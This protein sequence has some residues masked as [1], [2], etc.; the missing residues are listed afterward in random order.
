MG[1]LREGDLLVRLNDVNRTQFPEVCPACGADATSSTRI[2][3]ARSSKSPNALN[4]AYES[5][6]SVM[7]AR[8]SVGSIEIPVCDTHDLSYE[9]L[10]RARGV[11][12]MVGGISLVALFIMSFTI[13]GSLATGRSLS[14]LWYLGLGMTLLLLALS[15]KLTGPNALEKAISLVH[16]EPQAG[17][18]ILRIKNRSYAERIV[19][20]NPMQAELGIVKSPAENSSTSESPFS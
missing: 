9:E 12:T 5:A 13:L 2:A 6:K 14:Y 20:L 3:F 7:E 17:N 16:Y 15:A 19:E 1:M 8:A 11:I 4:P 10:A 18:V